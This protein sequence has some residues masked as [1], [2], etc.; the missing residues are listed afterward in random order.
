MPNSRFRGCT[1]EEALLAPAEV[2]TL[3]SAKASLVFISPPRPA[4]DRI[5]D[6]I[7]SEPGG[8]MGM[9]LA[10]KR[11]IFLMCIVCLVV[12]LPIVGTQAGEADKQK[13][14]L[15]FYRF[16]IA[17]GTFAIF[18]LFY[19]KGPD[20][21]EL[22]GAVKFWFDSEQNPRTGDPPGKEKMELLLAGTDSL[23]DVENI[24]AFQ[25]KIEVVP[26]DCDW[27]PG[28]WKGLIH[29]M[30]SHHGER[31]DL[32]AIDLSL[33][34]LAQ[35]PGL[36]ENKK[37][38][39]SVETEAANENQL[40]RGV[41]EHLGGVLQRP[42]A[43]PYAPPEATKGSKPRPGNGGSGGN[44][45]GDQV[46]AKHLMDEIQSLKEMVHKISEETGTIPS[47]LSTIAKKLERVLPTGHGP[48]SLFESSRRVVLFAALLVAALFFFFLWVRRK[49]ARNVKWHKKE[50]SVNTEQL[51]RRLDRIERAI[52]EF[53]HPADLSQEI[54]AL[55][56]HF[57]ELERLLADNSANTESIG[58]T[59]NVG[60][61]EL[62]KRIDDSRKG[63][64]G[65]IEA[66]TQELIKLRKD[67]IIGD[68][69]RP[70]TWEI[71][72]RIEEVRRM[73]GPAEW[74]KVGSGTGENKSTPQK[75]P[76][77]GRPK[78]EPDKAKNNHEEKDDL[79][80][81]LMSE[82]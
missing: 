35:V 55:N 43:E 52:P 2:R 39:A 38:L 13:G 67:L 79:Q 45:Q 3:S 49:K 37:L 25:R 70:L 30:E 71:L 57:S 59:I 68:E 12:Q 81:W 74:A 14:L 80:E 33:I 19:E 36:G 4:H 34:D 46:T 26:A 17:T 27:G 62:I 9:C 18:N 23:E 15:V 16:K 65:S 69:K 6:L 64:S 42:V 72:N 20:D 5:I 78:Q 41:I 53:G 76:P 54:N 58:H 63:V 29:Y 50:A 44:N 10:F 28:T 31:L 11:I 47:S 75:R 24:R 60:I 32:K 77:A 40:P 82:D 51:T 61:Q 8:S 48:K 1:T 66:G 22:Q 21:F 7:L 56:A 73:L